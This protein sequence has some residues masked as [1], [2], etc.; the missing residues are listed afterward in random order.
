M[1]RSM[2][3][4]P[5]SLPGFHPRCIRKSQT[6]TTTSANS[7]LALSASVSLSPAVFESLIFKAHPG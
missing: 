4:N 2:R 5:V 3:L 7:D 6:E 1:A